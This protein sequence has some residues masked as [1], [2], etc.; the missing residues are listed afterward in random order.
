MIGYWS[1]IILPVLIDAI[2]VL[3]LY[4]IVS[5]G[6]LS[7]GHAAFF[8]IGSYASAVLSTRAGIP[9]WLSI[10][11]GTAAAGAIGALFALVAERLSHWFFAIATLAFSVMLSGTFSNL[12]VLGGAT[13][14]YGVPLEID[15]RGVAGLLAAVV[16]LVIV[17]DCS[18]FG[19]A[20]RAVRNSEIAAQALGINPRATHVSAFAIGTALAGLAGGLW[21]H[22]MG[23]V[24][25][26]DLSL[27]HSLFFL[28]Y[29]AIGGIEFWGGALLGTLTL[30]L[31]PEVLR[32]S[33]EYRL[34]FFGLLL[35]AVMVLRPS[36][37]LSR[38]TL[39]QIW[40]RLRLPRT[41]SAGSGDN[42]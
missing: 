8:G 2:A 6:R 42:P 36:G 19:R 5:S 15:L 30:G 7:I 21:A 12:E 41:P 33:R 1:S 13:G 16:L 29:L 40:G 39:Q 11:A 35:T 24:K 10:A 31:L 9:S 14:L 28:V 23:L 18:K 27:D 25:P 37:L 26:G 17:I 4:V 34:A 32:F 20:L 3:G 38:E 22:Y